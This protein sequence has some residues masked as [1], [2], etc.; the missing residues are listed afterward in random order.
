[1]IAAQLTDLDKPT[2]KA[3]CL[4]FILHEY[5]RA[6]EIASTFSR[7]KYREFLQGLNQLYPD[8][9]EGMPAMKVGILRKLC[10]YCE[11]LLE[12]SQKGEELLH[13]L[14]DLQISAAR[15]RRGRAPSD[16]LFEKLRA[17]FP[18]LSNHFGE[19]KESEVPLFSLLEL[20]KALNRHLGNGTVEGLFQQ[21]F[22]TPLELQETISLGFAQRGFEGFCKQH[23]D[24]FEGLAWKPLI[25][26]F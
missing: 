13:V 10:F 15:E 12:T 17:F 18:L 9:T 26:K 19:G 7:C 20:R 2:A 24:L 25:K 1:M 22:E 14:D 23:A 8:L 3:L 16:S 11:A 4:Q 5:A 21:L 6:L